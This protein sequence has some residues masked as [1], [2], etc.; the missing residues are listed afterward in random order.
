MSHEVANRPRGLADEEIE[1]LRS[2]VENALIGRLH[3]FRLR[4]QGHGLVLHGRTRTY[5]GKQLAQHAVMRSTDLPILE[6]R[7]EVVST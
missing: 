5:Y 6:N 3:D 4:R 7:I 1:H 2:R